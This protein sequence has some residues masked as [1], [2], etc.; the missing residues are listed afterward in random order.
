MKNLIQSQISLIISQTDVR[1]F[2]YDRCWAEI[3]HNNIFQ[4]QKLKEY[5]K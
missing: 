3:C 1:Q 4:T 5:N 2:V